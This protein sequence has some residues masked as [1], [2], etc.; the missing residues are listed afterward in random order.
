M[1]AISAKMYNVHR[2]QC[3]AT[4]YLGCFASSRR[5]SFRVWCGRDVAVVA[6]SRTDRVC[7]TA[8]ELMLMRFADARECDESNMMD[9][10]LTDSCQ[11]SKQHHEQQLVP[12]RRACL[13]VR[14]P[15]PGIDVR[16]GRDQARADKVDMPIVSYALTHT[17]NFGGTAGRHSPLRELL[18]APEAWHGQ[19]GR[20]GELQTVSHYRT[21]APVE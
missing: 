3:S 1:I 6:P 17:K 10:R 13:E 16:H 15:V 21:I 7:S 19:L 9:D 5:N 8:C 14:C 2:P 4:R 11:A 12:V 20:R 18:E